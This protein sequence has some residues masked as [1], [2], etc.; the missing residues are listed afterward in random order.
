LIW[1]LREEIA[2][3]FI[4]FGYTFK[5]DVSLP[6]QH[7]YKLVE[8]TKN[9]IKQS[10]ELSDSE[11]KTLKVG[12]YGHIGDGNLH[13]NVAMPGYEDSPLHD[14]VES[15]LEPYVFD[16]I[17]G[18]RGS[19]SAEHGIGL[20]KSKYLSFSK[21]GPMIDYMQHIKH[22]FDPNGIMN[23]YKVLPPHK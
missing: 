9:R 3:G 6:S 4:K 15:L 19:V 8:E 7:F 10:T 12:G 11:K 2:S 18:V 16:Y 20:Q 21:S 5:Y 22:V 14:K 1:R 23:P 17:R 13:L